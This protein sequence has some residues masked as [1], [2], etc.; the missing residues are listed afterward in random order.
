MQI[1]DKL[2]GFTVTEKRYVEELSSDVYTL[3][4]DKTGTR[5]TYFARED[6]NKTFAVT[7]KT[8]PSDSTGVFHI[9]EHSVLCGSEKYPVKDPFVELLK[10]SLNTFLN[11]LTFQ[12]K[13]MY[14]VSSRNDKDFLKVVIKLAKE[15]GYKTVISHRSGDTEDTFIADLAVAVNAKMIKS[16]APCR[17]DR[18][19]K[20]NR[21]LAIEA[22][23]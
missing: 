21:L 20:Y 11:A 10:G 5:L 17:T 2:Y 8:L 7:F 4:Y 3:I 12:D 23:N 15:K 6:D 19:A 14:P 22:S 1:N 13:T 16:G 9:I 18:V